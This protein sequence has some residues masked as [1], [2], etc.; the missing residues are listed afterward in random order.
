MGIEVL[1]MEIRELNVRVR[2]LQGFLEHE[3]AK[4]SQ[5]EVLTLSELAQFI[6]K[7]KSTI[8]KLTCT[9]AIP[10]F[11]KGK[12]LYFDREAILAWIRNSEEK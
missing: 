6:G 11:K 9:G 4:G 7:S 3:S 5:K 12:H 10:H 8:Y 1:R 2:D